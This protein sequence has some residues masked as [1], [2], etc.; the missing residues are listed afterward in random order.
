MRRA[1]SG[2][3]PTTNPA[4]SSPPTGPGS[5]PCRSS[6]VDHLAG[7]RPT[8][9]AYSS[10]PDLHVS[11]SL[12]RVAVQLRVQDQHRLRRSAGRLRRPISTTR[13]DRRSHQ[14][15][16]PAAPRSRLVSQHRDVARRR[17]GGRPGT[18]SPWGASSQP[19][20]NS[21]ESR[22]P[23]KRAVVALVDGLGADEGRLIDV[24]WSTP[25]LASLGVT[26]HPRSDYMARLP[27]LLETPPSVLFMEEGRTITVPPRA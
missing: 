3:A 17:T 6:R 26:E 23:R 10:W 14:V 4:R 27:T 19:N 1:S 22:M 24:Q 25:H 20:P 7:G 13:M 8:R 2:S 11:R 18:G 5:S 15:R 12:A 21:T 16:L 9:V